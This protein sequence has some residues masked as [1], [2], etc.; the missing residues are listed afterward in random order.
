M[1]CGM[2]ESLCL[3]LFFLHSRAGR[4]CQSTIAICIIEPDACHNSHFE[5]RASLRDKAGPWW[6]LL[7]NGE[8]GRTSTGARSA[9]NAYTVMRAF[10]I[11][12]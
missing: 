1:T 4:T 2:Y 8:R 10:S 3:S 9:I 7:V 11:F 12:C 5:K 6:S